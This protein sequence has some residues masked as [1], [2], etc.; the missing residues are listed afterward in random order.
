M[1]GMELTVLLPLIGGMAVHSS[2]PLFPAD[3]AAAL[4]EVPE[5]RVLVS[6]PVHLRA[7]VES[8]LPFPRTALIV[9]ATAP[10]DATLAAQ[11]EEK[12]GGHLLEMFGST[13]TC[14]FARRRTALRD[15]IRVSSSVQRRRERW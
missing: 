5:P 12:L 1:Y 11:I 4:S 9:S 14:V 2:R 3:I 10:L 8:V 15:L 7:L 6:T 13:E